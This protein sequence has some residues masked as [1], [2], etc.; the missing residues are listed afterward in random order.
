M[1]RDEGKN[2]VMVMVWC[3]AKDKLN[4]YGPNLTAS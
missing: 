4:I 3:V 2:P 1:G